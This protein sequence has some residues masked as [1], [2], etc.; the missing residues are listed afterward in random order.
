MYEEIFK[1]V[2][3][4]LEE[5][6]G[7]VSN[8]G[9][10]PY[11]KRSEHIKRV[12]IWTKRLIE[13]MN[14]INK[15]VVLVSA[16][17]HDVGYGICEDESIHAEY[18]ADIC[19]KYLAEHGFNSEFIDQVAYLVRNHSKKELLNIKDTPIEL[20]ILMEADLLDETGALSIVWDCMMEGSQEKQTFEKTYEHIMNY[21]YKGINENLMVTRK[22]VEFWEKKQ[23][24]VKEFV[25]QL[26]Y[27]LGIQ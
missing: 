13:D 9:Y 26:T 1:F 22:A 4:Y 20:I 21:T 2:K 10:F 17:F 5:N 27:D 11:R 8:L 12:F 19:E 14:N 7:E 18:S 16:L 23:K 25:K 24:L 15:E 3:S 6:G